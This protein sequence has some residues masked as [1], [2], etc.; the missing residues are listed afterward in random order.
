MIMYGSSLIKTVQITVRTGSIVFLL[1]ELFLQH[2]RAF[3][4]ALLQNLL[5]TPDTLSGAII[6]MMPE[7]RFLLK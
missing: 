1:Q 3:L 7:L 5:L 2:A 6:T 4:L